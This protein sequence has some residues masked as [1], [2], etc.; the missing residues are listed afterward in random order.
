MELIWIEQESK[1]RWKKVK[2]LKHI[3]FTDTHLQK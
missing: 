1:G 2:L 3:V